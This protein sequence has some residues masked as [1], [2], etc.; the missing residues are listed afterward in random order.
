LRAAGH[1]DGQLFTAD[2]AAML[3]LFSQ[4][5]PREINRLAKLAMEH[6]WALNLS[7]VSDVVL[8]EVLCDNYRQY[9]IHSFLP[10]SS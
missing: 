4:G 8:H 1:E 5:V 3:H 10:A 9:H 2:A 7:T 6:A